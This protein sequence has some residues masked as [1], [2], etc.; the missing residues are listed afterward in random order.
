[1]KKK[2]SVT[3]EEKLIDQLDSKLKNSLFRNKSHLVEIAIEKFLEG[4]E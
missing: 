2:L 3:V 1:M 4:D